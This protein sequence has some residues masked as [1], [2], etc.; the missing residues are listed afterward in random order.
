MGGT[1]ITYGG[2]ER[3]MQCFGGETKEQENNL[4]DLQVNGCV[5]L[6]WIFGKWNGDKNRIYLAQNRVRW[7]AVV[8]AVMNVLV[9]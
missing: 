2:E 9:P 8:Y 3:F 1:C 7:R 5:I 6:K 4:I